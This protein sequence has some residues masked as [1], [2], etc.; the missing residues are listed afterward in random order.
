MKIKKNIMD[1]YYKYIEDKYCYKTLDELLGKKYVIKDQ[2]GEGN[3]FRIKIEDGLE[4]SGFNILKME[5]DFDNRASDDDILEVGYCYSGDTK[6]LSLPDYKE[7]RFKEGDLFIY[8][9]LNKLDYFKFKYINCK[10][11]SIHMNFNIIK[12]AIN[13]IRE[14]QL[15]TDWQKNI[16]SIFNENILIIEKASYDLR[17]IA[18]QIDAIS[19]D[20][21]I[22]YMKLKLKTIEFL[23]TFLEEKAKGNFKHIK[24]KEVQ[25]IT[26]AKEIIDENIENTPSVK[27]L[28]VKLN[29]SVYKLQKGFKDIT[30]DTVYAYIKKVKIEKA[31]YLLKNTDMSILE[32]T[33]EIGY[34][35]PSKFSNLFKRYNDITPLKYRKSK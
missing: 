30:G 1:D 29:T 10:A 24:N 13:S 5:M 11:I 19:S 25:R 28:A 23:A 7:Y 33:N 15:I 20:N 16:K 31:K 35:N 6:I 26:K 27:E 3:F 14:D 4:I 2:L 22:G 12:N 17:K 34:E 8:K 18:Q 9:T 21:M 32:I